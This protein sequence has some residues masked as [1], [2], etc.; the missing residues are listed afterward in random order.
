MNRRTGAGGGSR[1]LSELAFAAVTVLLGTGMAL[2][3]A[4]LLWLGGSPYYLAAGVLLIVAGIMLWKRRNAGGWLFLLIWLATL[5]WAL[6]ESGLDGWA[7]L[8]R[9]GLLTA[10]GILLMLI[11]PPFKIRA[12]R[13]VVVTGTAIVLGTGA[14]VYLSGT[15][16]NASLV[17]PARP[18]GTVKTDGDW[19]H[20]GGTLGADRF[21][22][23]DQITPANVENLEVVWTAHLGMPSGEI[24]GTI[25]ATPLM[26]GESL[27]ICT[28]D[29]R[30]LSLDA[31]NGKI[32]WSFDPKIDPA[33]VAMGAC[34]GVAY[35]RQ[36]GASGTCAARIFVATLDARMIAV[37]AESGQRCNGFG[38]NGEISLLQGMGDVPKGYYYQT[39]P[40]A[41][42]RNRLVIGG[43]VAD[44]QSVNEP[45]GVI[46]AFD[47][48][49]GELAWAWDIGRP[50][51]RGLPP[52]GGSYTRGTPNAWPPISGDERLGLAFVPLGNPT[53]DYVISHRSP[54]MRE[55]GSAIVALDV[56]T[57]EERWHFQT[58]HLDVWDYDLPAPPTLVDFPTAQG[59][60]PA[61][62]QPTKR[63][64]FFVLDRETG[65]PLVETVE[66]GVPSGAVPGETLSPTQ[67]YPVGMPSMGTPFLTEARMWG[68]TIFDQLWCRIRFK[69]ARYEGDF[70]PV[71]T[72]PTIVSPGYFGGSNWSGI[73][74]D[75][76]RHV[77][78]ANVMHFPMYN[79]LIPRTQADP[80][81]FQP[82]RVG[83]HKISG[84]NWAQAGTPYAVR[85]Q[86]F[87]SP[88]G[89]PCNQP[90]Y[91]EIAAID[92]ETRKTLWRQ[93]LGTARDTGP[94][95]IPS[96]LPLIVGVPAMGGALVTR[97][98]LVFIAATQER[99]FRAFDVQSGRLLWKTRLPAGGH[100]N[101]MTY[102]SPRSGRQLV[103][104]PASGHPRF[105]NGSADLLIAYGLPLLGG[106]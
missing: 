20:I 58:T 71:G 54:E 45:S 82:A 39:S 1:A 36:A 11:R 100:A 63:G 78:V 15:S 52:E 57:G 24:T 50:E 35:H 53:P 81:V 31:E 32:R 65:K 37:D 18:V 51:N 70:T 79:R 30:V 2:P 38:V 14:A 43:R 85:T 55:Y 47:A 103:V 67:P 13:L 33:G 42:I 29:N 40:P 12:K 105:G 88:L 46:R 83:K 26:V 68:V 28:M 106:K 64:E 49:T 90:P 9:L 66:R 86:P 74:V 80:A 19:R 16:G 89:I 25:E 4:R 48:V 10:M 7:L 95:N 91:A 73:A 6:W 5:L 60:R 97:S 101:P 27:Y 99:A 92:L 23:L 87:V 61:L 17:T 34:R 77:M 69:E 8:P 59:L 62:I 76:E 56:E 75:P 72:D 98:G 102:R 93:P 22:P 21:S 3:G 44:G 41:V 96:H 84:E 104:I 94:W